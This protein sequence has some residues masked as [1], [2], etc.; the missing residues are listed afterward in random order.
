MKVK[1]RLACARIHPTATIG[2]QGSIDNILGEKSAIDIG[3]YS[4]IQGHLLI[5][6]HGGNISMGE[7]CFVGPRTEIWSMDSITIGNR[8]LI[9]HDVNIHDGTGHSLNPLERHKHYNQLIKKGHPRNWKE[10]SGVDAAPIVIEDDVW[11]SFCVIVLKGVTIGKGSV[12]A[13]GSTVT[14]D[15]PKNSLY[16]HDR[17]LRKIE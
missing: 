8:V 4:R 13:A 17:V 6:G 15:V 14:K 1:T 10:L 9:S 11:I 2:F 7:Y 5:Y 12:I 3:P 16:I